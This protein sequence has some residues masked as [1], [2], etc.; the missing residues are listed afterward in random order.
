MNQQNVDIYTLLQVEFI[1]QSYH[2]NPNH[3]CNAKNPNPWLQQ[4]QPFSAIK[5]RM[6]ENKTSQK[7]KNKIKKSHTLMEEEAELGTSPVN[8]IS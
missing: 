1:H 4:K 8:P 3:N 7:I 5:S 2:Y 6:Q